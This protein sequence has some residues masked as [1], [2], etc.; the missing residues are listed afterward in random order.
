MN[1][2]NLDFSELE[3]VPE[4]MWVVWGDWE[5]L[6]ELAEVGACLSKPAGRGLLLKTASRFIK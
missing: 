4:S 2:G 5:E 6:A 1:E 3:A